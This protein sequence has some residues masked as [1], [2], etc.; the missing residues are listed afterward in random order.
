MAPGTAVTITH[1]QFERFLNKSSWTWTGL[2]TF[3][4][5]S[6]HNQAP[7]DQPRNAASTGERRWPRSPSTICWICVRT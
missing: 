7:D 6:G 2:E 5:M 1:D 4:L 3:K